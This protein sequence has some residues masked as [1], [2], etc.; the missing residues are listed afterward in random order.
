MS[1]F[2]YMKKCSCAVMMR[3]EA[4]SG[5]KKPALLY[6]TSRNDADCDGWQQASFKSL[7]VLMLP[8]TASKT[9]KVMAHLFCCRATQGRPSARTYIIAI[10]C[11]QG[12]VMFN[13][14][15]VLMFTAAICAHVFLSELIVQG[16]RKWIVCLFKSIYTFCLTHFF[17]YPLDILNDIA[18]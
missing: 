11:K 15:A 18:G 2:I 12:R 14:H 5:W 10:H 13:G 3:G 9:N 1:A 17:F 8:K 4:T 6:Q 16:H 7:K